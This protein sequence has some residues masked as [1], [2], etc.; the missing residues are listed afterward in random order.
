MIWGAV[1]AILRSCPERC[2]PPTSRGWGTKEMTLW[3][4]YP[5]GTSNLAEKTKVYLSLLKNKRHCGTTGLLS[6]DGK[7]GAI[8]SLPGFMSGLTGDARIEQVLQGPEA[9]L[10]LD[11]SAFIPSCRCLFSNLAGRWLKCRDP[12]SPSDSRA[13]PRLPAGRLPRCVSQAPARP[14]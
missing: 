13:D 12:R 14:S 6:C 9:Q 1:S 4:S 8:H 3:G 7:G 5:K 10:V 2:L 11:G